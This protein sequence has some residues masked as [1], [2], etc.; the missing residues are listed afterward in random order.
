MKVR[1]VMLLTVLLQSWKQKKQVVAEKNLKEVWKKGA[2]MLPGP[3][4]RNISL[5]KM[6]MEKKSETVIFQNPS[7]W[8]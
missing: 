7:Q 8:I 4:A 1:K 5:L 3:I 6:I 2:G